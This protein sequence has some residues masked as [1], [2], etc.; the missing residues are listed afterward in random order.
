MA[1]AQAPSLGISHPYLEQPRLIHLREFEETRPDDSTIY[2]LFSIV[3]RILATARVLVL[4]VLSSRPANAAQ[5]PWTY[6]ELAFSTT[7]GDTGISAELSFLNYTR[8]IVAYASSFDDHLALPLGGRHYPFSPLETGDS[9]HSTWPPPIPGNIYLAYPG[10]RSIAL[11]SFLGA[12]DG[13]E[14]IDFLGQSPLVF[15]SRSPSS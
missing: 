11:Y 10:H 2:A 15:P 1:A 14:S 3:G 8:P 12:V 7:S 6:L 4:F 13:S 5:E 9:D